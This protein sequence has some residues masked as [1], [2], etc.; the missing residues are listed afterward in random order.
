MVNNG[1]DITLI[2]WGYDKYFIRDAIVMSVTEQ[3]SYSRAPHGIDY[4]GIKVSFEDSKT[5]KSCFLVRGSRE[6]CAYPF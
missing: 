2:R 4:G 6:R 1:R 3:V 5:H